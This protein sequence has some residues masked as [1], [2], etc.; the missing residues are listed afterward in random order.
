MKF[1]FI[2]TSVRKCH[3]FTNDIYLEELSCT[4]R[5]RISLQHWNCILSECN[6]IVGKSSMNSTDS[7]IADSIVMN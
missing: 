1:C 5:N 2:V 7:T 6:L 4:A 3:T